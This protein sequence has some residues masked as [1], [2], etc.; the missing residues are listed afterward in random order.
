MP[1]IVPRL[2][3]SGISVTGIP[4]GTAPKARSAALSFLLDA[5]IVLPLRSAIEL[6][7]KLVWIEYRRTPHPDH[8]EIAVIVKRLALIERVATRD[9]SRKSLNN[10]GSSKRPRN[11][12]PPQKR[13]P[14]R[15]CLGCSEV[16]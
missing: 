8:V 10:P 1:L 13:T 14:S 11:T 2:I 15:E 12:L 16:G 4:M 5:R 6:T 7:G 3:A 9:N